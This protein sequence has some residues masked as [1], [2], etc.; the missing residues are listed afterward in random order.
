[1][2]FNVLLFGV[3]VPVPLVLH[4]PEPV[5]EV[6]FRITEELLAQTLTPDPALT[7]GGAVYLIVVVSETATQFALLADVSVRVTIPP[8]ISVALGI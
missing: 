7:V 2:A 8:E 6:P 5:D 1:V 3:K 4:T